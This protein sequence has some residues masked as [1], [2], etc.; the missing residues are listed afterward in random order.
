MKN[1]EGLVAL[2]PDLHDFAILQNEG[3]YRIPKD[4]APRRW[5]PKWMA[6]Y[7][8]KAFGD[9][10]YRIR[11]YGE[12]CEIQIVPGANCSRMS[13]PVQNPIWITIGFS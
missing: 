2:L 12:V 10:A 9:D 7:Q 6:F 5:P 3:W 4:K 1:K 8:P 11:Y 13:S